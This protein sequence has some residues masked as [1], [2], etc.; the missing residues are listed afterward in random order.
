MT[1]NQ[2]STGQPDIVLKR[3][4]ECSQE[5]LHRFHDL[6]VTAGEV[7]TEGLLARLGR[8]EALVFL[9]SGNETIGVGALKRQHKNYI[10]RKFETAEAKHDAGHF[11]L[12][13]GWVV[14]DKAHREKGYSRRIVEALLTHARGRTI[15]ATS[16]STN[17]PMH[18]TLI[19]FKFER[20]GIAWPSDERKELKLVLF[21]K[22]YA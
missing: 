6:V 3:P 8:A 16:A 4:D 10:A 5:D 20:D 18:K 1:A 2:A 17:E 14:I 11:D 12:E 15:Y 19:N 7:K 21:V 13:L 9:E 22:N